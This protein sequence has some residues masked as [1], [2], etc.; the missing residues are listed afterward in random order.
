MRKL[1][2]EAKKHDYWH[3]ECWSGRLLCAM[4][5]YGLLSFHGNFLAP[6]FVYGFSILLPQNMWQIF[7]ICCGFLQILF[8]RNNNMIGRFFCSAGAFLLYGWGSLNIFLYGYSLHFSFFPCATF[9]LINFFAL[10]RIL[11]GIEREYI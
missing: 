2:K 11:Q 3:I 7:F 1:K 6:S 9:S 4:G 5:I 10:H 8:L